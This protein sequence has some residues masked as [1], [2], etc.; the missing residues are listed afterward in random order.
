MNTRIW[1]PHNASVISSTSLIFTSRPHIEI[2]RLIM[3]MNLPK[4]PLTLMQNT[5]LRHLSLHRVRSGE[6]LE[7]HVFYAPKRLPWVSLSAKQTSI[8]YSCFP[9][10][11]SQPCRDDQ[12]STGRT[13]LLSL[14]NN[15]SLKDHRCRAYWTSQMADMQWPFPQSVQGSPEVWWLLLGFYIRPNL[16]PPR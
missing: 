2:P 3:A 11:H 13:R 16:T 7:K 6:Y 1:E 4:G 8:G 9:N 10:L 14:T 12:N 15:S 5:Y